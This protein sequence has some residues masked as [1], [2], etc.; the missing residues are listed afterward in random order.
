[1]SRRGGT[2][3]ATAR[4]TSHSGD[5]APAAQSAMP[6][7]VVAAAV[8]HALT[9]RRPKTRYLLGTDARL[10]VLLRGLLPDRA[11]DAL[12]SRQLRKAARKD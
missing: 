8:A 4:E 2:S 11:W 9:A 12:M 3:K 6:A 5:G 10:A 1:M 7:S